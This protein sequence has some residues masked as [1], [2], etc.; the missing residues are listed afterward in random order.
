MVYRTELESDQ[1]GTQR[2][3]K[4]ST[5]RSNRLKALDRENTS[6]LGGISNPDLG[7]AWDQPAK[8]GNVSLGASRLGLRTATTWR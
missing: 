6:D 7:Y 4:R 8:V 2:D 1:V 3:L 5:C